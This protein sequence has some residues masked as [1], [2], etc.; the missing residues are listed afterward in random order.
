MPTSAVAIEPDRPKSLAQSH[1]RRVKARPALV[2]P[3]AMGRLRMVHGKSESR[4]T[5]AGWTK[6]SAVLY[7]RDWPRD[8]CRQ[9][10]PGVRVGWVR[11]KQL[12]GGCRHRRAMARDEGRAFRRVR[13]DAACQ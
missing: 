10:L 9:E 7:R 1:L 12:I 11:D 8:V 2:P 13:C 5:I 6:L 4:R 3:P